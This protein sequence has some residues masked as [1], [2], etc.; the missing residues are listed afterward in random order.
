[1]RQ[2]KL[3][4]N[5]LETRTINGNGGEQ[6]EVLLYSLP[7]KYQTAYVLYIKDTEGDT[8]AAKISACSPSFPL[9]PQKPL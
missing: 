5:N 6:Y 7:A 9:P 1:M 3:P 8:A 4:N 2:S